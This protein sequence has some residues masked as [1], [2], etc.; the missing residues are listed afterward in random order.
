MDKAAKLGIGLWIKLVA[1]AFVAPFV[2]FTFFPT[3]GNPVSN[4]RSLGSA[5]EAD[6]IDSIKADPRFAKFFADGLA[7]LNT[8]D[9]DKDGTPDVQ[10]T[11]D[12]NDGIP[13]SKDTDDD[14]DG[15]ED[16]VDPS[17]AIIGA[18]DD[19]PSTGGVDA[20]L[21]GPKG[22]KGDKGDTGNS[23]VDGSDGTDGNNGS[24][25]SDGSS[26]VDGTTGSVGP[27]GPVGPKGDK[28]DTGTVGVV[29]DDGVID[30]TL[31]GAD[32][33]IQL[34]LASGSGL[35]K[36]TSGLSLSRTC[37][38]TQIL[39]W[40]GSSWNCA[41]DDDGITYT[42]GEGVS[43]SGST[44]ANIIPDNE[45]YTSTGAGSSRR[46]YAGVV[47]ILDIATGTTVA[48][49]GDLTSATKTNPSSGSSNITVNFPDM[50]DTRYVVSVTMES[51]LS[52]NL[53]NDIVIPVV[54]N[55]TSSS[56]EVYFEESAAVEQGLQMHILIT[57]Y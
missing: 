7:S 20:T 57:E 22:D 33:D 5:Q 42:A 4:L 3:F 21:V 26:G 16:S 9:S 43:I 17:S 28:G 50:G 12:D 15:N 54:H 24:S 45:H 39:K 27:E 44:I 32:L 37:S 35:Q 25:G 46:I 31:T 23:G 1:V 34:V 52:A 38:N 48:A 36:T 11:D 55:R 40:N 49:Y 8:L 13:D 19:D 51:L 2:L 10:D 41:N 56:F 53:D 14:G 29:T 47:H 6:P 18:I 30:T